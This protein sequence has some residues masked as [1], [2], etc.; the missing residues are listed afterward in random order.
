MDE[1]NDISAERSQLISRRIAIPREFEDIFTHFYY[2]LND[3]G[4]PV[5]QK[6]LPT[7]QTILVFSLGGKITLNAKQTIEINKVIILSTVKKLLEYT[8]FPRAEMMVVNFNL[9]GFYRFFGS[10][11]KSDAE[12][13]I[14]PDDL[15]EEDCFTDLWRKLKPLSSVDERP[16]AAGQIIAQREADAFCSP[17]KVIASENRQSVRTLTKRQKK[18]VA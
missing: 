13:L 4:N 8:L 1:A 3:T 17:I 15:F 9:D 10:G 16:F 7:F 14:Q 6:L 2:A 11:L 12:F 18:T 5:T